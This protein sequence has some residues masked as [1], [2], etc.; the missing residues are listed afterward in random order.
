MNSAIVT[1]AVL[2]AG[3]GVAMGWPLAL[4]RLDPKL[5]SPSNAKKLLQSHLDNLFMAALSFGVA[6]TIPNIPRYVGLPLIIGSWMNPQLFLLQ[7]AVKEDKKIV[8]WFAVP[9]FVT[10]TFAWFA[11]AHYWLNL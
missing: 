4:T 6:A 7:A 2:Q 9:S 1:S 3:L 10:T 5:T 8:A 11:L